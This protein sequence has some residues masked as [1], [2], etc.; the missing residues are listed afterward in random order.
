[1]DSSC[2]LRYFQLRSL[3]ILGKIESASRPVKLSQSQRSKMVN[4]NTQ[5]HLHTQ[6]SEQDG[7]EQD[8]HEQDGQEEDSHEQA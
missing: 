5:S 2:L 4:N 6:H 7:H 3:G 1:M 8:G